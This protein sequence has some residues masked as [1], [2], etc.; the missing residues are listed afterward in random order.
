MG[1]PNGDVEIYHEKGLVLAARYLGRKRR[2]AALGSLS[3]KS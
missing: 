3:S 1:L 2:L